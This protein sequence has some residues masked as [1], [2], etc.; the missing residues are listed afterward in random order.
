M[1]V[2]GITRCIDL[3]KERFGQINKAITSA[4]RRKEIRW[5]EYENLLGKI[6]HASIGFPGSGGLF[7]P[8]NMLLKQ[9]VSW[10][11]FR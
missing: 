5:K 1:G 7:T 9:K 4:L 11:F 10:I 6:G 8:L 2:D 3:P